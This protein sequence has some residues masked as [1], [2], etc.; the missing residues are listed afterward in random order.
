MVVLRLE[1]AVGA[2]K[3]LIGLEEEHLCGALAESAADLV[4]RLSGDIE[5]GHVG[6]T[7]VRTETQTSVD[8]PETTSST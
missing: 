5:N 2:T 3:A 7:R 8:A 1:A 6:E 4:Q